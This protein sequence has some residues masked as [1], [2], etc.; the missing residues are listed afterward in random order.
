[1]FNKIATATMVLVLGAGFTMG[2]GGGEEEDALSKGLRGVWL[3]D[4][5][6]VIPT[7]RNAFY[8][9]PDDVG[10]FNESIDSGET[11]CEYKVYWSYPEDGY[12]ANGDILMNQN[13]T[14]AGCGRELGDEAL[15]IMRPVDKDP[16]TK[17][18]YRVGDVD[19][20][21]AGVPKT[22]FYLCSLD[23]MTRASNDCE[24]GR[25]GPFGK[26]GYPEAPVSTKPTTPAP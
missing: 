24:D 14:E 5:A 18:Q 16:V 17:I 23:D 26:D 25:G 19:L 21:E 4:A 7:Y 9:W 15:I 10:S 13:V 2:C 8:V 3:I 6:E 20:D 1:M 12:R 22:Y 11:W